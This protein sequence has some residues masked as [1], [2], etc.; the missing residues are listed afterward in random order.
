MR[1]RLLSIILVMTLIISMSSTAF[2]ASL[3]EFTPRVFV[4][5]G[6]A[7]Y[8]MNFNF[9]FGNQGSYVSVDSLVKSM[10]KEFR[11]EKW[12]YSWNPKTKE[13]RIDNDIMKAVYKI[14]KC[15][16]PVYDKQLKET[17]LNSY[18]KELCGF[19]M[20][21][22]I[23]NGIPYIPTKY[24]NSLGFGVVFDPSLF[25]LDLMYYRYIDVMESPAVIQNDY[26]YDST[27]QHGYRYDPYVDFLGYPTDWADTFFNFEE[28]DVADDYGY[29]YEEDYA[30]DPYTNI[31]DNSGMLSAEEL[32]LINFYNQL[33]DL[34]QAARNNGLGVG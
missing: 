10:Q 22:Q 17:Y 32:A 15:D 19:E 31:Y 20:Y 16:V 6:M 25:E 21:P 13:I 4:S 12:T 5:D 24:L 30:Y 9:Y 34:D 1:K 14:G 8:D 7:T 2:A 11:D 28:Y 29:S 33:F 23:I 18:N 26:G 3:G 27:N